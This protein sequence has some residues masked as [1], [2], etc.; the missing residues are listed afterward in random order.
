M[1]SC[2][3]FDDAVGGRWAGVG[4]GGGGEVRLFYRSPFS[5]CAIMGLISG[6]VALAHEAALIAFSS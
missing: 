6:V 1:S 4:G 5:R 2:G 3:L